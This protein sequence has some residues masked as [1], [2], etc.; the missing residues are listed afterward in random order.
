MHH[1]NNNI[2]NSCVGLL[3][4]EAENDALRMK[5]EALTKGWRLYFGEHRYQVSAYDACSVD[6]FEYC[7][8]GATDRAYQQIDNFTSITVRD[9]IREF[10]QVR[11]MLAKIYNIC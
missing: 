5:V 3:R 1:F 8:T 6:S 11:S 7:D 9:G 2:Y 10:D 4:M